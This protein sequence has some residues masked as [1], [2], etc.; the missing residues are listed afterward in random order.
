MSGAVMLYVLTAVFGL[1]LS[2]HVGQL[3]PRLSLRL[4]AGGLG[5]SV[6]GAMF[7]NGPAFAIVNG[8]FAGSFGMFG[9]FFAGSLLL[10]LGVWLYNVANHGS[11]VL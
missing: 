5:G 2:V 6:G 7:A 4:I 10:L 11:L 9:Y 8:A 3:N 1:A